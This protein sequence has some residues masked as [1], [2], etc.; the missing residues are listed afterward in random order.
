MAFVFLLA[1][2][3]GAQAQLNPKVITD[4]EIADHV[5]ADPGPREGLDAIPLS[6]AKSG[7]T[8]TWSTFADPRT[9]LPLVIRE[10]TS[11]AWFEA[12]VI[13]AP[14]EVGFSGDVEP[15]LAEAFEVSEDG[16]SVTLT[17]RQGLLWNDGTPFTVDDI[18]FSYETAFL[19]VE[20]T[21][22][23]GNTSLEPFFDSR[24]REA[25]SIDGECT[26]LPTIEKISDTQVRFTWPGFIFGPE[27][28]LTDTEF[29]CIPKHILGDSVDEAI[30]AGD[31][32]I[33]ESRWSLSELQADP[34][35]Y[36]GTG[37][38]MLESFSIGPG[39]GV[40]LVR[41]PN[42][43]KVDEAGNP[44]PKLDRL[45][46]IRFADQS[47]E[48]LAFLNGQTDLLTPR[49]E[50]L[51]PLQA[52]AEQRNIRLFIGENPGTAGQGFITLNAD[53]GLAFPDEPGMEALG[54]A[55][56][57]PEVRRALSQ[58]FDREKAGATIGQGLDAPRYV[59][60][61]PFSR[62]ITFPQCPAA[63]VI[64]D[65]G[66]AF[67]DAYNAVVPNVAFDI[68]AANAKL[69]AIGLVDTDGD[70]VRDI[71][72]GFGFILP[73]PDGK[74]DST[75]EGDDFVLAGF[76]I[77]GL[78]PDPGIIQPGPNG[79]LDTTP[80]G[81]DVARV[82]N[83][84]GSLSFTSSTN[85]GNTTREAQERMWV[86]D[87]AKVG[88][89]V[90]INDLDFIT[91][92]RQLL[93]VPPQYQAIVIGITG[94]GLIGQILSVYGSC[95]FLHVNKTSDCD[96]PETR[97]PYQVRIDELGDAALQAE[98]EETFTRLH[99]ELQLLQ[100][101]NVPWIFRTAR[102]PM[103]AVRIDRVNAEA[104]PETY[105]VPNHFEV[106]FAMDLQ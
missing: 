65:E 24:A 16:L 84:P 32:G 12:Y 39:G 30:A 85:V 71:P 97:E 59:G 42:Y 35:I 40:T 7:G 18:I 50:D 33:F 43:W 94:S 72:A 34:S 76:E 91:L 22:E 57:N 1:V 93:A 55:F 92:V 88:V 44:L 99:A 64:G 47:A 53:V 17:V 10:T 80:A 74:L 96:Q 78:D 36:V 6:Q 54:I 79:V 13:E 90:T 15:A 51:G 46:K 26:G 21:D 89:E 20:V 5:A 98:D 67:C 8:L 11:I 75:P 81:D 105:G 27:G 77:S 101:A 82:T 19:C 63:D 87:L 28:T 23:E 66:Q 106:L 9:G 56:S 3:W 14:L 48:F 68:D 61:H 58:A 37:P 4:Q 95:A 104:D 69:D 102:V 73:G 100:A 62:D 60:G 2:A 29:C 70:G 103:G 52:V 86:D 45:H 41:N 38:F 25:M 31:P 83:T 49:P